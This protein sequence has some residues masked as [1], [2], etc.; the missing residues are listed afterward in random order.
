M[1]LTASLD[2]R[3]RVYLFTGVAVSAIVLFG[4]SRSYFL[5]TWFG[6]PP[7]S[8]RLHLHGV[9]L[10]LWLVLF[11]VQ[12]TLIAAGRRRLHQSLGIAGV[13][14]AALAVVATYAAAIEAARLGARGGI[15]TAD[16]LY[17]S[18]VVLALFAVFVAAGTA[19]RAR[20]ETHKRCM[21][22]ATIAVVGPGAQRAVALAV[23]HGVRDFHVLVMSALLLVAL[24]SDW[25]TRGRPHWVLL[26]GGPLLIAS[27]LTRRLIGASDWWTRI[28]TWLIG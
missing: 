1:D 24:L 6:T 27:Q 21:L 3:R 18:V 22:L 7:L 16:R 14:L 25:M 10:S 15:G 13:G 28:G 19:F 23:G 11:L 8:P 2:R 17:S 5:K 26:S 4:F 12:T 20:P 9:A